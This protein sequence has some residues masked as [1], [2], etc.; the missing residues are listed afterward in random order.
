MTTRSHEIIVRS[1]YA[2]KDFLPKFS[3]LANGLSSVL[4]SK[5]Q[6]GVAQVGILNTFLHRH[7]SDMGTRYRAWWKSEEISCYN[8]EVW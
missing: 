8:P 4:V 7:C 2:T 5:A 1:L 3:R 6:C